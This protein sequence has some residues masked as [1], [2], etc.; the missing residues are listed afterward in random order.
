M[1]VTSIILAG[2]KNLR[3]GRNKALEVIE[4]KS[5]IERVFD[6]LEPLSKDIVVVTSWE[7]F[8]L[9][10]GQRV[11]V[12]ADIYPEKGPLGGIYS[13]L[14]ASKSPINVIVACD[15][16]FLNTGL[17]RYMI[18][19]TGEH[20]AVVP[21][22]QNNMI[23][24]LHA[25]YASK[26]LARIDEQ[27]SNNRLSIHEFLNGMDVRYLEYE[28]SRKIDPELLSYFNINYQ[29]DLDKAVELAKEHHI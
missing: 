27:I 18:G 10:V 14:M 20:D 1:D 2:G 21:R 3:L 24:P 7:Q 11:E 22:L 26:C 19:L 5:I 8:D 9:P 28:E 13:G 23:E 16:P 4:G 15:M 29:S 12:V 17:L 6:R 25:V